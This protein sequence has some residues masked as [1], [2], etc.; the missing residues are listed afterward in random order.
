[1]K[2]RGGNAGLTTLPL[3][4]VAGK[5]NVLSTGN[6]EKCRCS[7][8]KNFDPKPGTV[9]LWVPAENFIPF[10]FDTSPLGA[11]FRNGK[12]ESFVRSKKILL[13][14]GQGLCPCR[15]PAPMRRPCRA[16]NPR[17]RVPW[18]AELHSL[19]SRSFLAWRRFF[20]LSDE[21]FTCTFHAR[22]S[23]SGRW[24]FILSA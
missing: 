16:R 23:C 18:G 8:D 1:M 14:S 20:V 12:I 15:S 17:Y 7:N 22:R 10:G 5:D 6:A 4:P 9:S 3:S 24:N 11:T 2:F 19:L 13:F 21:M